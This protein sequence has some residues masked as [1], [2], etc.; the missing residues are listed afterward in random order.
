MQGWVR[1]AA[2]KMLASGGDVLRD[3]TISEIASARPSS[4]ARHPASGIAS[5]TA[6]ADSLPAS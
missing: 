1:S 3:T 2:N 4:V 6:S 5:L